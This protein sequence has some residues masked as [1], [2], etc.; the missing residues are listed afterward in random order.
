MWA[1]LYTV[2]AGARLPPSLNMISFAQCRTLTLRNLI[3]VQKPSVTITDRFSMADISIFISTKGKPSISG[4]LSLMHTL[5]A[6]LVH[7]IVHHTHS[8]VDSLL[9][10]RE[11]IKLLLFISLS[12]SYCSGVLFVGYFLNFYQISK[13]HLYSIA[14]MYEYKCLC[15]SFI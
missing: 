1:L 5:P 6:V 3:A 13:C 11:G 14:H 2:A 12:D 8:L 10:R 4:M 7:T 9:L 15:M